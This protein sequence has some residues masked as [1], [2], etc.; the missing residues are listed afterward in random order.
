MVAKPSYIIQSI[1]FVQQVSTKLIQSVFFNFFNCKNQFT[2]MFGFNRVHIDNMRA[3]SLE[4][5]QIIRTYP[6]ME[7]QK[8]VFLCAE[9][10]F[11]LLQRQEPD[12]KIRNKVYTRNVAINV[13]DRQM[14]GNKKNYKQMGYDHKI[15]KFFNDLKNEPMLMNYDEYSI[16]IKNASVELFKKDPSTWICKSMIGYCCLRRFKAEYACIGHQEQP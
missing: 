11:H 9:K 15:D 13:F 4:A 14:N 10:W 8:K 1:E 7:M 3:M 6:F 12:G 16:Q 5:A 2:K